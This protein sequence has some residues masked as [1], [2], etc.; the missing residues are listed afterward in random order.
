MA[1]ARAKS[2]TCGIDVGGLPPTTPRRSKMGLLDVYVRSP[3]SISVVG[4]L[5]VPKRDS[6]GFGACARR[7]ASERR[8]GRA[9]GVALARARSSR[10][11]EMADVDRRRPRPGQWATTPGVPS[12]PQHSRG[13]HCGRAKSLVKPEKHSSSHR[14]DCAALVWCTDRAVGVRNSKPRRPLR[15]VRTPVQNEAAMP[16]LEAG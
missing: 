1:L 3:L 7:L 14:I 9:D 16:F 4:S 11:N 10:R 5:R 8:P 2:Y 15:S 6:Q 13:A 12:S